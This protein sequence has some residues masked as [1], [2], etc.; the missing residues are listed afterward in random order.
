[1]SDL[2]K[3]LAENKKEELKLVTSNAKNA[4]EMQNRK[5]SDFDEENALA[6]PTSTAIRS[7]TTALNNTP[8]V[9]RNT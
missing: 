9:S 3:L 4:P 5:N 2:T 6:M 1:M 8:L 7:K